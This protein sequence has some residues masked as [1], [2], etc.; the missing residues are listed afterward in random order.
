MSKCIV[1]SMHGSDVKKTNT[2]CQWFH[3]SEGVTQ[4]PSPNQ[5][6]KEGS[7]Q[8]HLPKAFQIFSDC[9]LCHRTETSRLK[10]SPQPKNPS[11]KCWTYNP[12]WHD[13][14]LVDGPLWVWRSLGTIVTNSDDLRKLQKVEGFSETIVNS[15][16]FCKGEGGEKKKREKQQQNIR[17]RS[18]LVKTIFLSHTKTSPTFK[19][20]C[21][22]DASFFHGMLLCIPMLA[23]TSSPPCSPPQETRRTYA[24]PNL[25]RGF[26]RI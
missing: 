24:H 8:Y 17:R 23:Q 15:L 10:D 16:S 9:I 26:A 4:L 2:V 22:R 21:L 6:E 14:Q 12:S 19:A 11:W 7:C 13:Q 5:I 1:L 18:T 3:L 25:G 20:L